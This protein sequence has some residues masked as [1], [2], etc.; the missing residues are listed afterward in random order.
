LQ[1]NA[2]HQTKKICKT[3]GTIKLLNNK[4]AAQ[5]LRQL[6]SN[7]RSVCLQRKHL[8]LQLLCP[9]RQAKQAAQA[10]QPQIS[11]SQCCM[12]CAF[13]PP[14]S[15]ETGLHRKVFLACI[16]PRDCLLRTGGLLEKIVSTTSNVLKNN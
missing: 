6:T 9:I 14:F 2:S 4:Q 13:W 1:S 16:L 7:N 8:T 3:K 15:Q 11:T 5:A 10:A 12:C